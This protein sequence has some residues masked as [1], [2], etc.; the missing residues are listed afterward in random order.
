MQ[1]RRHLQGALF[2]S[3]VWAV[4]VTAHADPSAANGTAGPAAP[5]SVPHTAPANQIWECTTKGVRTFSSNPCGEH[6]TVRELNP[7]NVME[8]APMY[9]VTHTYS[10]PAAQTGANYSIS[11]PDDGEGSYADNAYNATPA[12]IVVNR[13]HRLRNGARR[14]HVR[15][16]H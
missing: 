13:S 10:T 5:S 3:L 6:P 1:I 9:R 8:P 12:Y 4:G 7:I 15:P 2:S 14:N 11:T 16:H